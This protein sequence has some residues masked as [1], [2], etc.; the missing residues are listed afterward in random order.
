[1]RAREFHLAQINI[2]R[3]KAPL[4]DPLMADFVAQIEQVDAVA[5]ASPGFVWR[6][7]DD[8]GDSL[9]DER[10]L[11][12]MSVWETPEAL[13]NYVFESLHIEPMRERKNWFDKMQGPHLAM[14]WIPA[15]LLPTVDEA[16]QRLAYL[17]EFGPGESAF[18]FKEA[19]PHPRN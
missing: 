10:T 8:G 11:V 7:I 18:T 12:N 3:M 1:M 17:R 5:E 19:F 13:Q 15:G 4:D 14:W 9:F 2:A 16:K 6:Y